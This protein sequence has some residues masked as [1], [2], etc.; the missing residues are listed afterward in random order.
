MKE[1]KK[2]Y[3]ISFKKNAVLLSYKRNCVGK[4]EKELNLYSGAISKWRMEYKKNG[5]ESFKKRDDLQLNLEDHKIRNIEN[6]IKKS[7]LQLQILKS[8]GKYLFLGKP[9]IYEFMKNNE[10]LYSIRIMSEVLDVNRRTYRK[11]R[12]HFISEK[13]KRKI[14]IMEEINSIFF[15]AKQRYGSERITVVLRTSGYKIARRTVRKYMNELGLTS[16]VKK[17]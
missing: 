6:K 7:D 11:W 3:D 13:E 5:K 10:T 4:L 2:K 16:I 15:A 12:N 8:A 14:L 17:N 1:I 9:A